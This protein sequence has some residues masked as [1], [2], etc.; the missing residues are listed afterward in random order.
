M[1][2]IRGAFIKGA[3]LLPPQDT[4]TFNVDSYAANL[5]LALSFTNY[6]SDVT[7]GAY[8]DLSPQIRT[9]QDL[10]PGTAK[11]ATQTGSSTINSTVASTLPNYTNNLVFPSP[12]TSTADLFYYSYQLGVN[13]VLTVEFWTYLPIGAPGGT[14]LQTNNFGGGFYPAYVLYRDGASG[15]AKFF[16]NTGG[17][18]QIGDGFVTL[19]AWHHIAYV[20]NGSGASYQQ[21]VD[22]VRGYNG[23]YGANPG[24]SIFTI[25]ASNWDGIPNQTGLRLQDFRIYTGIQKYTG[26]SFTLSTTNPNFGGAILK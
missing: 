10:T 24:Q 7:G 6:K 14:W 26:A 11:V 22:G 17:T 19:G 16:T 3:N 2:V 4:G 8:V 21:Y 20:F 13:Q 1:A 15:N 23:T 5:F 25:G 9:A 18:Q 12:Q